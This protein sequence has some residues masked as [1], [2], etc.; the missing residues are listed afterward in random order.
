MHVLISLAA[1]P[2]L[3]TVRRVVAIAVGLAALFVTVL[4]AGAAPRRPSQEQKQAAQSWYQQIIADLKPLDSSLVSG[5]QAAAQWQSGKE[6]AATAAQTFTTDLPTLTTA[7]HNLEVQ[8]PLPGQA[9]ALADYATAVNLYLQAFLLEEA[10]TQLAPGRLASQLQ[11]SF[12]R[13]RQLGDVTYDVGTTR[14]APLLGSSLAGADVQA[15]R[16]L[17]NWTAE[18]LAPGSPLEGLWAAAP[19]GPSGAHSQSPTAWAAAVRRAGAP[20]QSATSAEVHQSSTTT[21]QLA[22]LALSLQ[23]AE[24]HLNSVPGPMGDALASSHLRLGLLVDAEAALSAEAS[25]LVG[26]APDPA[27]QGVAV[28]LVAIGEG[29]RAASNL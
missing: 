15:G 2:R 19:S 10:A 6:S 4:P 12:L 16:R 22:S 18:R 14:L 26:V 11:R 5:L 13:I 8:A 23:R 28:S 9:G 7:L 21:R 25:R 20:S 27:L 29:L 3:I 24:A 17:P 1:R